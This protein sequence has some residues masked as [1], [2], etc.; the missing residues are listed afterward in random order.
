MT[1][2][3]VG[4]TP[5]PYSISNNFVSVVGSGFLSATT[6]TVTFTGTILAADYQAAVAASDYADT[7]IISILP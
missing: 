2:A 4:A 1:S 3:A 6:S 5:L 7:V